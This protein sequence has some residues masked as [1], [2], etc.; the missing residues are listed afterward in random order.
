MGHA[1]CY[2]YRGNI[3]HMQNHGSVYL[4]GGGRMKR[5]MDLIRKIM[6]QIEKEYDSTAILNLKVED[7]TPE[8]IATHCKML[9]E[10][11]LLSDYKAQYA[12]DELYMFGVGN[13]TWEGYD[14]L[15]K[16][17]DDSVWKKVKDTAKEHGV[18]LLLDTVKQ[19]SSA[20]ISA[21]TEG[22]IKAIT[23]P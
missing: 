11:G 13:L 19:I 5:D 12:S 18:P 16:I 20:I 15:D 9:Y 4:D 1:T 7:Y 6:L 17:R 14:Y 2:Y 23:G 3:K 21:M 10:A 8:Q 22:A